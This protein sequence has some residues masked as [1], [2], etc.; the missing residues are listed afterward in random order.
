MGA[1][2]IRNLDDAVV[3][4]IKR[5]AAGNGISMEEEIRRLLAST[6]SDDRQERGREWARRQLE[7]LKRG[8]L[9]RARVSSVAEIRA[10]R[11]ARTERLERVSRGHNA[12]GR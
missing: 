3:T 12:R 2:T 5:Q 8:E 7:R 6:Y 10:M 9:P 4:A 1:I 11:R